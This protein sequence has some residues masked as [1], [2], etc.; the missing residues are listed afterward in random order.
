MSIYNLSPP[1][2][3]MI[4]DITTVVGDLECGS[5]VRDLA[6]DRDRTLLVASCHDVARA[7]RIADRT[8]VAT[9]RKPGVSD[10]FDHCGDWNQ[11]GPLMPRWPRMTFTGPV[12][13][14]SR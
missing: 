8:L 10:G 3:R 4:R 2:A 12:A 5:D 11:S 9:Y 14:L 13:G 7:W 1:L 6:F